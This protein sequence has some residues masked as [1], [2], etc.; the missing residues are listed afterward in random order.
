MSNCPPPCPGRRR[1]FD[2][3]NHFNEYAGFECDYS[4]YP[5][6]QQ[7]HLFFRHYLAAGAFSQR[8]VSGSGGDDQEDA[9]AS[10]DP[11]LL[12]LERMEAEANLF[13]LASHI[14]WGVWALIQA[15]YSPIDFDY[16]QYSG[17]RWGEY[18][19]R[20]DE[21]VAQASRVLLAGKH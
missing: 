3:G 12:M 17:T 2:F 14:Y 4:R 19:R 7:Q 9:C 1:G 6:P 16:L 18:H 10:S 15:R 11:S 5:S 13:A 20:K 21:F 8:T